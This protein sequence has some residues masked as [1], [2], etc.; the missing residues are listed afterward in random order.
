M[1]KRFFL[2]LLFI[3]SFSQTVIAQ[4]AD[5]GWWWNPNESGRGFAIEQQGDT[6]FFAS[7]LYD[8]SSFPSWYTATLSKNNRDEFSGILQQFKDGQT[9]HGDFQPAVLLNNIGKITLVFSDAN[10]GTLV[11]PGGTVDITRFTFAHETASGINDEKP[12]KGW[13]WDPD[14]S[15]RGFAL[16]QQGN[17]IFLAAFLYDEAGQSTWYTTLLNKDA[18][19]NF[20]GNLQQF[21]DGQTLLGEYQ[22]PQLLDENVG[23]VKLSFTDNSH[24]TLTWPGGVVPVSRFVFDSNTKSD[25]SGEIRSDSSNSKDN[26]NDSNSSL[27]G[28]DN[29]N[30]EGANDH[31]NGQDNINHDG[32]NDHP[33]GQEVVNH[34]GVNDL[35]NGNEIRSDSSNSNDNIND[36]NN[37]LSGQDSDNHDRTND[38]PN[39]Q[40]NV[41][42]EGVNDHLNEQDSVNH[43]GINDHLS[44][45]DNVDHDSTNDQ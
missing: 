12:E 18:E 11:W 20:S 1:N 39:G 21:R 27:N 30:H 2:I 36:S 26:V 8:N 34:E 22:P 38:H 40:D 33:N 5:S 15:G 28:Q 23:E 42:H 29:V 35:L 17:A 3:C 16:E 43:D 31:P 32:T 9:L 25:Q 13:W 7:F 41:N 37:S 6:I 14:H 19:Q 44:G 4:D 24:G 10:N 45:E